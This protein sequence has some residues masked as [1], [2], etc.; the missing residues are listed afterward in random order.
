MT[1]E[2]LKAIKERLSGAPDPLQ[3]VAG[4]WDDH[5][6]VAYVFLDLKTM[7]SAHAEFLTHSVQDIGSLISHITKLQDEIVS[8][9]VFIDGAMEKIKI[10]EEEV[11]EELQAKIKELRSPIPRWI[12]VGDGL[13]ETYKRVLVYGSH[14]EIT[15]A[16]YSDDRFWGVLSDLGSIDITHWM[17]ILKGP[18]EK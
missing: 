6:D 2:E 4:S 13:P 14:G 16:H 1:E 3:V 12:P 18:E 17:E 10:L 5:G 15:I 8:R 7:S 9:D 11:I